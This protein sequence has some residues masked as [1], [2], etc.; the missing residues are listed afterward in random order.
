MQEN[1]LRHHFAITS[2][3]TTAVHYTQVVACAHA[4]VISSKP[5][6]QTLQED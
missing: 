6:E 1:L 5:C 3:E 2:Y 4:E